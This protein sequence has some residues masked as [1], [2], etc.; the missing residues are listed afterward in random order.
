MKLAAY[1]EKVQTDPDYLAAEEELRPLLDL[2]DAVLALRL[3]HGWSQA[4]LAERVGTKQANISRLESGLA[5]PSVKFLQK[6]ANA[7]GE[8]LIIQLH[9]IPAVTPPASPTH[10]DQ[11]GLYHYAKTGQNVL[12]AVHDSPVEWL[13]GQAN[14]TDHAPEGSQDEPKG[15]V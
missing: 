9:P 4:E 6:V 14:H 12:P 8:T 2:A 10:K 13:A 5:N 7:F 3:A 11:V 1:H 15:L